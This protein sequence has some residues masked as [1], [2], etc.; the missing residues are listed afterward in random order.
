MPF[1]EKEQR[2]SPEEEGDGKKLDENPNVKMK[3]EVDFWWPPEIRRRHEQ[4]LPQSPYGGTTPD[5]ALGLDF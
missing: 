4:I 2:L 3:A 5:N 1:K